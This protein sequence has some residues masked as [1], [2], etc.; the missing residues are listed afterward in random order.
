M[1]DH[2]VESTVSRGQKVEFAD[3]GNEFAVARSF[4]H[5]RLS[6]AVLDA[7]LINLNRCCSDRSSV[8]RK[9]AIGIDTGTCPIT[10]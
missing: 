7:P 6:N 1:A 3:F 10:R 2:Y 5:T 8:K 9:G 4:Q